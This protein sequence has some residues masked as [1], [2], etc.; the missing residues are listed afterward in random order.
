MKV[1][2]SN[3][4]IMTVIG[5]RPELIKMSLVIDKFDK[6]TNQI[7]VHTGQNFDY[8]LNQVFFDDMKIRK[9]DYFLG[10]NKGNAIE[11]IAVI[12]KKSYDVLKKEKPDALLIYG[13][14]NSCLSAFSAKKLKIPIF[15]MEAGNRCFDQRVPEE[16]NRKIIDHLS[17]V[18][19][20][21]TEQARTYLIRENIKP[22]LI[23]KTGSHLPEVFTFFKK[24]ILR[25]GILKKLNLRKS[26]YFVVSFH[27]EENVDSE[28]KLRTFFDA[29][30]LVSQKY[31]YPVVMTLHP[32][33][34]NRIKELGLNLHKNIILSKP[35]GFFDYI[36]LEK[37]AASVISD[38]GTLT[39]EAVYFGFPAV[40]VRDS[41]ERPEGFD[42]GVTYLSKLDAKSLISSVNLSMDSKNYSLNSNYNNF[43]YNVSDK[44]LKIV[45]SY[46]SYVNREIWKV[47]E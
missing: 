5:T 14:T 7:L 18:N 40:A 34:E 44:I 19:M 23:F 13:D 33:T 25:S 17:D 46:I 12:L 3:I 32:R 4:K 2:K 29:L 45:T 30:N 47:Y 20:V 37:N 26:K 31:N 38:S 36:T 27:R 39:E 35:F 43:D 24:N 41:H 8:S 6:F 22:E 11:N 42:I 21:L 16:V 9:P 10:A 1:I 28:V 15:H